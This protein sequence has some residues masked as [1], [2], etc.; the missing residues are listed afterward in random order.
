MTWSLESFC[1]F[2]FLPPAFQLFP[3]FHLNLAQV[4]GH[5]AGFENEIEDGLKRIACVHFSE[6]NA[7]KSLSLA[8]L[9][10]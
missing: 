10:G 6:W 4:I 2:F 7:G 1:L 5:C 9:K 8:L 3:G